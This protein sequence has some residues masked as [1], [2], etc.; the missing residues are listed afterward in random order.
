[1]GVKKV[2]NGVLIKPL[3]GTCHAPPYEVTTVEKS[4]ENS[5]IEKDQDGT[6]VIDGK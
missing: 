2:A 6:P 3:G 4:I 1:M 5:K